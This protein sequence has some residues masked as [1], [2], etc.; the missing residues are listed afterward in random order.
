MQQQ[1]FLSSLSYSPSCRHRVQPASPM[2]LVPPWPRALC[3]LDDQL[4]TPLCKARVCGY[5]A[6]R[7]GCCCDTLEMV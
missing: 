2:R 6:V 4:S 7:A 3:S 5:E 1:K